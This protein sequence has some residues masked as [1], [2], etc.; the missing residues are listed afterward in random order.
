[1]KLGIIREGKVPIDK[2]T[3]FTPQNCVELMNLYPNL[4]IVVQPSKIRT[5]LDEEYKAL[6]IPIS[7]D[8]SDCDYIFGIKQ[9]PVNELIEGK[10]YFFFSHTIKKQPSNQKLLKEIIK[11]KCTLIDYECIKDLKNERIISFGHFAGIVGAYNTLKTYGHRYR[12]FDLKPAYLCFDFAEMRGN[13]KKVKSKLKPV[14][15]ALT[16]GGRVANGAMAVLDQMKIKKVNITQF[17]EQVFDYP[18]YCQLH[19]EQFNVRKGSN[20]FDKKEFYKSPEK[21]ESR[22]FEFAQKA[23]ILLACA[24]WNP[25]APALFTKEQM[26]SSNFR[27]KVIGDITCDVNGSIPSTLKSTSI[28]NP[29]YDYNP[30]TED[31]EI[32]YSAERNITTMAIDNL[33]CELSRDASADFGKQLINQVI[34]LLINGD[35]YGILKKATITENGKLSEPF[36]Y[37]KD[38]V[39]D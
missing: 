14:K 39:L 35:T 23:D 5:I 20:F 31:L 10:K 4:K 32:P 26:R 33:P 25:A 24:F 12:L 1:M 30:F 9:V 15:I 7:E 36:L 22:F 16:G 29:V 34:P 11:K 38:Y 28:D 18:V 17:L 2:R 13:F 37:L 8:L 21:Y 27:I 3:P 6:K 19:S